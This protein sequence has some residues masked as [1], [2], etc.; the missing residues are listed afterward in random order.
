MFC[1]DDDDDGGA[2]GSDAEGR[3]VSEVVITV[4]IG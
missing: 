1:P 2:G 4:P 3:G